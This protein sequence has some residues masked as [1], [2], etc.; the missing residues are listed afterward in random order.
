MQPQS[1]LKIVIISSLGRHH[2]YVISELVRN[3]NVSCIL[4]PKLVVNPSLRLPLAKRILKLKDGFF[5]RIK[6]RFNDYWASR[7]TDELEQKATESLKYESF[8]SLVESISVFELKSEIGEARLKALAPD[9]LIA[10]GAPILSDRILKIARLGSINLHFGHIP[11][12]RGQNNLFFALKHHDYE[13][14]AVTIHHM[15]NV[16][17]GGNLLSRARPQFTTSSTEA[18]ILGKCTKLAASEFVSIIQAVIAHDQVP[19]GLKVDPSL[20]KVYRFRDRTIVAHF[21]FKIS[22]LLKKGEAVIE[23]RME[24]FY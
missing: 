18:E 3:F 9:V 23:E 22:Q 2:R 11:A 6:N 13:N 15:N 19:A 14:I 16:L 7:L 12:Y 17:D 10:A 24:R 21:L 8:E 5:S 1:N 20:S 4:Q